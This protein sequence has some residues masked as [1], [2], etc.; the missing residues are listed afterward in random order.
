MFCGEFA[1]L[2]RNRFWTRLS[3][4]K[5]PVLDHFRFR[6]APIFGGHLEQR[7][8]NEDNNKN[9]QFISTRL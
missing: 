5:L 8:Y 9:R 3:R 2:N 1:V 6:Q 4:D 7:I